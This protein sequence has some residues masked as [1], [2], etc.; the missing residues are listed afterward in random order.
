[1]KLS[2]WAKTGSFLLDRVCPGLKLQCAIAALLIGCASPAFGEEEPVFQLCPGYIDK[3]AVSDQGDKAA[4]FLTLSDQGALALTQFSDN[5][6][7]EIIRVTFGAHE[8]LR[9]AIW[10]E[11]TWSLRKATESLEEAQALAQS[12]RSW[13]SG[14]HP[15]KD[16][17]CGY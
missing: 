12:I 17:S 6:L 1:M 5:Q 3:V 11:E 16:R 13:A 7:G 2:E 4:V 14:Q 8:F 15:E 9:A 10:A